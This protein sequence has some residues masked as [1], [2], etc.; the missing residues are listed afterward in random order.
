MLTL[1]IA[2]NRLMQVLSAAF[3]LA[4]CLLTFYLSQLYLKFNFTYNGEA[5]M[6][7]AGHLLREDFTKA[8]LFLIARHLFASVF[9]VSSIF[10]LTGSSARKSI[11]K[12]FNIISILI[13]VFI[14]AYI[15]YTVNDVFQY[16]FFSDPSRVI[17]ICLTW[18]LRVGG[19]YIGYYLIAVLNQTER[20]VRKL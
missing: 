5:Y 20:T 6:K 1:K 9:L 17:E 16:P 7:G 13:V 18:L 15:F 10:V 11:I 2:G 12:F 3:F 8:V 19:I 4:A 14:V